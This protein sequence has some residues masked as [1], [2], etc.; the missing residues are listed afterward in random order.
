M[1]GIEIPREVA[2]AEGVPEDLDANLAGPYEFPNP[3]R[4]RL[5]GYAFLVGALIAAV[6]GV[7]GLPPGL[8]V[9]A[10]ALMVIGMFHFLTAWELKTSAEQALDAAGR[11]VSFPVGLFRR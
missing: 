5:S 9:L 8:F 10:G 1:D 6:G 4:R 7:G 3:R 2:D 11:E